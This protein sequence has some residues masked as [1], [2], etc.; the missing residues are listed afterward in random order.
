MIMREHQMPIWV[1]FM[2]GVVAVLGAAFAVTGVL[3]L[4]GRLVDLT[5][6]VA[7]L[8]KLR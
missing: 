8:E 3:D 2:F 6:R 1:P 5:E 4:L 7:E